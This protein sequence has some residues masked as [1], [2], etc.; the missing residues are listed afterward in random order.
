MEARLEGAPAFEVTALTPVLQPVGGST[1]TD[2]RWTVRAAQTGRHQ[3]HL[4]I[5]AII[6]VAGERYPRSLDV[7]NRDIEVD[8]SAGQ[9]IGMF[10]GANWQWL[11]GTVFI[12]LALWLWNQQ[13]RKKRKRRA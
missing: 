9:R 4:T 13:Y 3:L 12:P 2:W 5:N 1:P 10:V 11:F 7:L 8:I 6:T